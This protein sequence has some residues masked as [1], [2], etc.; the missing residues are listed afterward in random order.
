MPIT[1]AVS[2]DRGNR[3]VWFVVGSFLMRHFMCNAIK[4]KCIRA[5]YWNANAPSSGQKSK[6]NLTLND[7][8]ETNFKLKTQGFHLLFRCSNA[9]YAHAFIIDEN[10]K[11]VVK[12]IA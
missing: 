5:H 3:T 8:H 4:Q 2:N 12:K 11:L 1:H 9:K 6:L 10:I 7:A